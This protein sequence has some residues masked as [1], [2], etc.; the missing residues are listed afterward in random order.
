MRASTN[1]WS[2]QDLRDLLLRVAGDEATRVSQQLGQV[3]IANPPQLLEVGS[4]LVIVGSVSSE[5][6]L[7]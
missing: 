2:S 4:I 3:A 7:G 1:T 6:E 5:A